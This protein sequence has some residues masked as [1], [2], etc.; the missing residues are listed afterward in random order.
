MKV[1]NDLR[2]GTASGVRGTPAVFVNGRLLNNPSRARIID[3]V[4]DEVNSG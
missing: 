3:A 2:G 1:R 4:N